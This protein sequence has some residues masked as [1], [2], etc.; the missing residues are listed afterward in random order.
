MLLDIL[1]LT[2]YLAL[3][4]SFIVTGTIAAVCF[5]GQ[6]DPI[7]FGHSRDRRRVPPYRGAVKAP[8]HKELQEVA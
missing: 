8:R 5:T 7:G 2:P 3:A 6:P 4:A 1:T